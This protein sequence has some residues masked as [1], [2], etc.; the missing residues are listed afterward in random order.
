MTAVIA[1]ILS[2]C[3][4]FIIAGIVRK[5]Y[6]ETGEM[7]LI[8]HLKED[9]TYR[10]PFRLRNNRYRGLSRPS[11]QLLAILY[12]F[13][14]AIVILAFCAYYYIL[15]GIL[16]TIKWIWRKIQQSKNSKTTYAGQECDYIIRGYRIEN[17]Q[18]KCTVPVK[19]QTSNHAR[20][21]TF[22]SQPIAPNENIISHLWNYGSEIAWHNALDNYYES[23]NV[24]E[25]ALDYYMENIDANEIARL[26]AFEFY[27]FLYDKY[28][29]W[30]YTAKNRLATTRKSLSRYID[31]NKLS[32]LADIQKRLFSADHSNIE[33]CLR[34]A[35]EIRGLGPAGASGLL[36]ILFPESFGTVDQYVVKALREVERFPY[37][38]ELMKMNPDA[39]SIKNGVLLI[40]IMRKQAARLNE[41]FDTDFWTPRKIDMVFWSIGRVRK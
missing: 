10:L 17:T 22:V 27:A 9:W 41:L 18:S 28:F 19:E 39:L 26:S 35:A 30:K 15:A 37:N 32:E 11:Y 7:V 20:Q 4:A 3:L 23:L 1:P 6:V 29:V 36:S 24:E 21:M 40:G 33:E 25:R 13:A 31:E 5:I 2:M 38:A 8:E 14:K 34:I 12:Y 16:I